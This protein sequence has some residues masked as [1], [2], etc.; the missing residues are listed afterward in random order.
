[1][2]AELI[3]YILNAAVQIK[4]DSTIIYRAT[5]CNNLQRQQELT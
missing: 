1:M 4:N 3:G 5:T 2:V